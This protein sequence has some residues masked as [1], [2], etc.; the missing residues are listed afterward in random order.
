MMG[1]ACRCVETLWGNVH[2]SESLP[3]EG[4]KRFPATYCK[5]ITIAIELQQGRGRKDRFLIFRSTAPNSWFTL[6]LEKL[7]FTGHA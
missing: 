6:V 7:T 3:W 2:R 4:R 5:H 1:P